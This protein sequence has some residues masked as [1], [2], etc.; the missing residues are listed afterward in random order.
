MRASA[1]SFLV[2]SIVLA[3]LAKPVLADDVFILGVVPFNDLDGSP[4]DHDGMVD[5]IFT[6]D[7]G[8][9]TIEGIINCNDDRPLPRGASACPI[10]LVVSGNLTMDPG[11]GIF[12]ENRRGRGDGGD[13]TMEVGGDLFLDGLPGA[14]ISS[15]RR[16]GAGGGHRAG[17]ILL[18]VGGDFR[19]GEDSMVAASARKG[20][21][22]DIDIQ[23]QGTVHID[24]LVA[25][26]P[27]TQVHKKKLTKRVL[28]KL[29]GTGAGAQAG[30]PI[31][32]TSNST[33][34]PAIHVGPSGIVVSQGEDSGENIVQLEGCCIEI[35]GLLA[36]VSK[37]GGP[38]VVVLRSGGNILIDGR[39][40][41]EKAGTHFGMVRADGVQKGPENYRI[42]LFAI[43]KIEIFGPDPRET[44]IFAVSSMPGS[45]GNRPAGGTITAISLEETVT[46]SGNAFG[47][48]RLKGK[49]QGGTIDLQAAED[50]QLDDATLGGAGRFWKGQARH[51]WNRRGSLVPG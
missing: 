27:S 21:S 34:A 43:G 35:E 17:N 24:G 3:S 29:G 46:A 10:T 26:G 23:V 2:A 42:D 4:L 14:E 16:T 33:V 19:A 7:N 9:L 18:L 48:G 47:V 25:S 8:N 49:D 50:V 31:V 51:G 28:E 22:G 40:L 15:S 13:I 30:G 45:N 12:A 5:G 20:T 39:D 36:S 32:I 1:G 6:V 37:K 44:D 41:G 38:S 11:S